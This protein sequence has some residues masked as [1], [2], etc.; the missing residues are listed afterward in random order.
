MQEKQVVCITGPSP[1]G[2]D[3]LRS[4]LGM[5]ADLE[6]R[7]HALTGNARLDVSALST[8][9]VR[10][11]V[12]D[13]A[14]N[15]LQLL[16]DWS[17]LQESVHIPLIV[18]GPS[19][20]SQLMRRAMQNGARDFIAH[21]VTADELLASVRRVLRESKVASHEPGG[22]LTAVIDAK[23]GSGASFIA[24][25]LAH[26]LAVHQKRKTA[27]IDMDLQFGALPLSLDLHPRST[28]FD[29]IGGAEQLDAV[30]LKAYMTE[31]ASGLQVLGTM[32]EQLVMPWE[33]SV[34]S[35]QKVLQVAL[36]SYE[37]IVVDLPRAIDP[38]T[39]MVLSSADHVLVIMQRSFAHLRDAQRMCNLLR[40]YLGVPGERIV[41]VIN[42]D[43][44]NALITD[45]DVKEAIRP[46]QVIRI[47]NDFAHVTESL[48]VGIPLYQV[49]RNAEI[50][51]ALCAVAEGLDDG[52]RAVTPAAASP[53][54]GLGRV[55]GLGR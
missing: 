53:R 48:N 31:H 29:A 25:N 36:Q 34:E 33:V 7:I 44:G 26:I 35:V 49:A 21:P 19:H 24:C 43:E 38:L 4:V 18:V 45:N 40:G 20:D 51:A 27:L 9:N 52:A 8:P 5:E 23:G 10:L 55:F 3:S 17:K 39:G 6:I 22:K 11:V 47:P 1:A 2:C 14:S 30:A 50:T 37:H 16:Q 41:L 46:E 42:R 15:G 54:R 32:T 12:L 28:L 13:L